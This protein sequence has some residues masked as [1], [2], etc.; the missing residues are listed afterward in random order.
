MQL[1]ETLKTKV[2]D[3]GTAKVLKGILCTVIYVGKEIMHERAVLLPHA[4]QVFLTAYADNSDI[5]QTV[6]QLELGE[7]AVKYTRKWLFHQIILHLDKFVSHTCA[8]KKFGMI[9]FRK[10]GDI[11]TSLSWA[12]KPPN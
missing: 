5:L 11:L 3:K 9:L 4:S 8:H 6:H 12:T 1:I 2:S 10:G 7:G